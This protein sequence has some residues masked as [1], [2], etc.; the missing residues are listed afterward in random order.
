MHT[1]YNYSIA[2]QSVYKLTFLEFIFEFPVVYESLPVLLQSLVSPALRWV[3]TILFGS[4]FSWLERDVTLNFTPLP[5]PPT[6][7]TQPTAR[8]DATPPTGTKKKSN[9][10]PPSLCLHLSRLLFSLKA[11]YK[12]SVDS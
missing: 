5:T 1:Y 3:P 8:H 6:T 12:C 10:I 11:R 7:T 4:H 9:K 2:A